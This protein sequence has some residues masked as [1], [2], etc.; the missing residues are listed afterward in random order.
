MNRAIYWLGVQLDNQPP[1]YR[2]E[3]PLFDNI[4]NENPYSYDLRPFF[5]GKVVDWEFKETE[6]LICGKT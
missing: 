4:D 5:R 2:P 1:R 6:R 3:E